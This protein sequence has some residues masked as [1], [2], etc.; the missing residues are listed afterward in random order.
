[1]WTQEP[2]RPPRSKCSLYWSVSWLG[3]G[4]GLPHPV[5]NGGGT[6]SSPRW[7]GVTPSSLYG[8]GH[9]IQS[10][11]GGTLRYPC[12]DLRWVYN[13]SSK[14]GY[15]HPDLGMEYP[16]SAGWGTLCPDLGWVPLSVGWVPPS[17][18]GMGYPSPVRTWD[19][20]PTCPELG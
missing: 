6:P 20:V 9:P 3:G 5:L 1:M 10:L 2:Y 8:G 13:P 12:P 7:G 17:G 15:S 18:P 19:W 11:M 4:R 14:I 16:P